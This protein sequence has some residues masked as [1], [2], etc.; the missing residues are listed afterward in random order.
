MKLN[1]QIKESEYKILSFKDNH[2][3]IT[4]CFPVHKTLFNWLDGIY[5]GIDIT[6][7]HATNSFMNGITQ[8]K[9]TQNKVC[10]NV[11]DEL[12]SVTFNNTHNIQFINVYNFIT[13]EDFVYYVL[14][15]YKELNL[16]L[17]QTP[18]IIWGIN[19]ETY[20]LS[21]LRNYIAD[22]SI[23]HLPKKI[24]YDPKFDRLL[25]QYDFDLFHAPLMLN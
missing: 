4:C 7:I 24:N 21:K 17:L 9:D 8:D 19:E 25:Q 13:D 5:N 14:L 20:K 6:Y 1:C 12:L 2:T 11:E 23:G 3:K 15:V 18:L 22:I 10:L 16:D